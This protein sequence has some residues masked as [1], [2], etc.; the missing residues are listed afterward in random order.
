MKGSEF[1]VDYVHILYYKCHKINPNYGG[2]YI[3]PPDWIKNKKAT[4]N[5]INKKDN[6]RFQYTVTVSL[7]HGEIGTHSEKITNIK[8]FINRYNCEGINFKSEK[9]YWKQFDK[10]NLTIALNVLYAKKEKIDPAYASKNNSNCEKQVILLMIPN[11]EK[12]ETK[13]E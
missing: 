1:V 12:R 7:N 8:P 6:K 11:G 5:P 3:D 4:I 10:N 2:S 9:D 13:P